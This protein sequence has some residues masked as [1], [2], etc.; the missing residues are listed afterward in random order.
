M[1]ACLCKKGL[2]NSYSQKSKPTSDMDPNVI[3]SLRRPLPEDEVILKQVLTETPRSSA[4]YKV[5]E[6]RIV[7]DGDKNEPIIF[8]PGFGLV[9]RS[10]ECSINRSFSVPAAL[11][12]KTEKVVEM[13]MLTQGTSPERRPLRELSGGAR[14]ACHYRSHSASGEFP[15]RKYAR[16]DGGERD[17]VT[18][19]P[20]NRPDLRSSTI[21]ERSRLRPQAVNS[22]SGAGEVGRHK[23]ER[24]ER[25]SISP[26][27][28]R[29]VRQIGSSNR[30]IVPRAS[31]RWTTPQRRAMPPDRRPKE[32]LENPLPSD[33]RGHHLPCPFPK[34]NTSPQ[35]HLLPG[36]G[37]DVLSVF[38]DARL[39][40]LGRIRRLNLRPLNLP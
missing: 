1:G 21:R 10:D 31:G 6:P 35:S 28:K 2:H 9:N 37:A 38:R 5:S 30:L 3:D 8:T 26:V 13:V 39:R 11:T 27:P 16:R 15:S 19:S 7:E 17:R 25:G 40:G 22:S 29:D 33:S 36:P 4:I 23:G 18:P 20:V 34:T 14:S 24:S 32:S 12:D